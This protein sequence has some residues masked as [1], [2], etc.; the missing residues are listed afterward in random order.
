MAEKSASKATRLQQMLMLL[1]EYPEGLSRAE[2]A[3][4]LGVHRSTV[5]RYV[6]DLSQLGIPIWEDER[7]IGILR[8]RYQVRISVNMH[9][10]LALHLATRLLTTRTDKHYPHAASALRKLGEALKHLAPLISEHMMRS[11]AVLEGPHRRHDSAFLEVLE[12][13]TRAWSRGE[14]VKVTH[15]ME[16]GQTFAYK[17]APYFIEPYAVGRTMHVIGFR[18]PPGAIRTFK[19]ERIRTVRPLGEK[20]TIPPDF[21]PTEYLKD[22]WGIWVSEKAPTEIVLRFSPRVAKRVG[23]TLWHHTQVLEP[24]PD[25][26]L[27]WR[28]WVADWRE[29]LPW[30]RGWGADVEALAPEALRKRLQQEVGKLANLYGILIERTLPQFIAHTRNEQGQYHDL[31]KHLL[32]VAKLA[33]AFAA[34]L[35]AADVA[36]YL[37]LWHDLGKFHPDFQRYLWDADAGIKRKGPDHKAAG[38][39]VAVKHLGDFLGML[40]QGHHGGLQSPSDFRSWYERNKGAAEQSLTVARTVLDFEPTSPISFP[41]HVLR[42]H[43]NGE[44]NRRSGEFFA[45]M[46]FSSL[47][48]ADFLDTEAHFKPAKARQRGNWADISDLWE[49]FQ[50]DQ[51]RLVKKANQALKI[52][53]IRSEI[54]EEAKKAAEYPPGLFRLTVPTGGGK[55]RSAMGFA[56]R[57][58]VKHGQNRIIVVVPYI[59]I[60]QQTANTYREIFEVAGEDGIVVL[61][62]HSNIFR[63]GTIPETWRLASENW[64]AP[65]IVTTT[66]Q[67]FESLFANSTSQTRKLHRI[68]N[69]VV[70]LDEAQSLPPHLLEPMLDAIQELCTHYHTTVVLSTATQPA[71]EVFAPF[72]SL[73]QELNAREIVPN[74]ERY[75]HELKRVEFEWHLKRPLSWEQVADIMRM[76]RHSLAIC[77]TK[78]DALA[79]LDALDDPNA[80]HLST[81]LCGKHR[82][83]VINEILNRLREGQPCRV[84][85][86]QVV[87]SGV[88]IDFPLVLRALG[89]LDGIIQAAGRAN[90]EGKRHRGRVVVFEPEQGHLPRGVYRQAVEI[91]RMLLK[92]LPDIY[93]PEAIHAYFSSLYKLAQ[94]DHNALGKTIQQYREN[95]DFP[96]VARRFRL[97]PDDT[98]NVVITSYGSE[99]E[100]AEV[101]SILSALYAGA[102]LTRERMRALQPYL[103]TLPRYR[104]ATCL[105][106]GLLMPQTSEGFGG[107]MWEWKGNYDE[108]RGI[109]LSDCEPGEGKAVIFS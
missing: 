59:T 108:R 22:A 61:E 99:K 32:N 41:Q 34:N 84:V 60:T 105:H 78:D 35:Q 56:L 16:D 33:S 55:T 71:F 54:Y 72:R 7:R 44:K 73:V 39:R 14:K 52:N 92:E 15:E 103:V 28:A 50:K 47:V 79:L 20:Y 27:V 53:R 17:F 63:N 96:E 49:R 66:V 77:N 30:I 37:G 104:A 23:E 70:I 95:W 97:I 31:V 36:Y 29:M 21:D 101:R 2:V 43:R 85:A 62:H 40:I 9:E 93:S 5:G 4:R 86:T 109:V 74:S 106:A 11:A 46:L 89:P 76:E 102:P 69:S 3:R 19:I 12:A 83:A 64:D 75:F 94:Q 51:Q 48:D 45:R 1:L 10:A 42:N 57:H 58:A 81:R 88:D 91:T 38:A 82:D 98:V 25:G 13:L 80:L 6:E 67:F 65:I 24:Q 87:E 90:R 8:D 68:A 26:A 107:Q 100:Q 18:E